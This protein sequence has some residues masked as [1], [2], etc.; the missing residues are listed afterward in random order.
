MCFCVG[1]LFLCWWTFSWI[2]SNFSINELI[3]LF[4]LNSKQ[5]Q[6]LHPIPS[7]PLYMAPTPIPTLIYVWEVGCPLWISTHPGNTCHCR[8]RSILFHWGQTTSLLAHLG[9]QDPQER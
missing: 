7:L 2:F 6:P 5:S 8:P 3:Y 4:T 9:E 1:G